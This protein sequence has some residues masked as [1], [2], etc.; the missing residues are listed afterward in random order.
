[1]ARIQALARRQAGDGQRGKGAA[2]FFSRG[3]KPAQG[4][5]ER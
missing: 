4:V 2:R 3:V 1:M 5:G